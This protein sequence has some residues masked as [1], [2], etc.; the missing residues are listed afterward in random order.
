MPGSGTESIREC[1]MKAVTRLCSAVTVVLL[2]A[3]FLQSPAGALRHSAQPPTQPSVQGWGVYDE[4]HGTTS[5][6]TLFGGSVVQI[7]SS[8]AGVFILTSTGSVYAYGNEHHGAMGNGVSANALVGPVQVS[9]PAGVTIT[10]LATSGA[11]DTMTAVDSTGYAWG[12]GANQRGE[13]CVGNTQEQDTPVRLPLKNVTAMAG[14][15]SHTLLVAG[16]KLFACGTNRDGELGIG[17]IDRH[18]YTSPKQVSFSGDAA[19]VSYLVAAWH[20]SG[21]ILSDGSYWDW[22]FNRFSQLGNGTTADVSSPYRVMDSG[23]VTA[24]QGGGGPTDG[25]S[26]MVTTGG[27]YV[28]GADGFG[29]LC[30]GV[31]VVSV[32]APEEL[33]GTYSAVAGGGGDSYLLSSTGDVYSCG[34]NS[35]GQ[36]GLGTTGPSRDTP[37]LV[38]SGATGL[39]S[40]AKNAAATIP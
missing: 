19:H 15:G 27:T 9:F 28:W 21:A 1:Q 29:Q 7:A 11:Y 22:G 31:D 5:P 36:L 30:N 12:W 33:G 18:D 32:P 3:V 23:V 37:S 39:T 16:G 25:S 2:A 13:L 40:T 8:N 17:D 14:A 38:L 4:I 34:D 6:T 26:V 35:L 20:D 24:A 10:G